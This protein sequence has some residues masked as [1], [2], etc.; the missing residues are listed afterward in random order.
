M[1]EHLTA[2]T[3][4]L[5]CILL[6][7]TV[8]SSSAQSSDSGDR[9]AGGPVSKASPFDLLDPSSIPREERSPGQPDE[10]VAILGSQRG[11]HWGQVSSVAFS[12]DG[13]QIITSGADMVLRLWDAET[14]AELAILQGHTGL[15]RTVAFSSDG[16]MVASA[17]DDKSIRL[18]RLDGHR[19]TDTVSFHAHDDRILTVCFTP[20]GKTLASGCR[21]GTVRVWDVSKKE[22]ELL[23]TLRGHTGTVSR[24][25]FARQGRLL[26][27][28]GQDGTVRLWDVD[29]TEAK[30]QEKASLPHEG[31]VCSV[32]FAN[33]DQFLVS[34]TEGA[35][36]N[37]FR[38]FPILTFSCK[39]PYREDSS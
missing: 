4:G 21:D 39:G 30:F 13:K 17:G 31:P 2:Y 29:R 35:S 28:S 7:V 14:L 15:L 5:L 6:L 32:C 38:V 34:G 9:A 18:W 19:V 1:K 23:A 33:A 3:V 11:R 12:P 27:S 20:D 10:L 16:Q 26:A 25:V 36:M 22:P 24:L 37:Y 8:C